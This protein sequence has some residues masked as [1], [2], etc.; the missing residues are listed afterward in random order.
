MKEKLRV[1]AAVLLILCFVSFL[2]YGVHFNC[3]GTSTET[4]M[5]FFRI[6]ESRQG[7]ILTVQS[8]GGI[9]MTVLLG[10]YGERINKIHGIALGLGVMGV[11]SVLIGTI[12]AYCRI[13]SGYGLMLAFSL[14][15]GLGSLTVDLLMNG[16]IT[17]V[18]PD[19]KNVFLPYVHAF[20]GV[21]AMLAPMYV[22]ALADPGAPE[23]FAVPYLILGI[24]AVVLCGVLFL[25]AVR[26]NPHTPY[27][28]MSVLRQR[29]CGNPAEVFRD[30]RA[31]LYLGACFLY[32]CFQ[33]GLSAWLPQYCMNELGYAYAS[34][35]KMA[36][37][38]FLGALLMRLV[39]PAIYKRISVRNFYVLT[40]SASAAV[41]ALFLFLPWSPVMTRVLI[42]VLGLLQGAS[43]PSMVILCSD[44]F[45]G[46]SASA[47]SVI[48]LSVSL[49]ALIAPGVMGAVIKNG[50]YLWAMLLIW[51]CLPLSILPLLLATREK[52]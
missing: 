35:A 4:M 7:M 5:G 29:A 9:V 17:D 20:Y 2:A 32:L 21:G 47:S 12:P 48:V 18:F 36:T 52:K 31:W 13:G 19:R 25:N 44:S 27:R 16:V 28:D 33:T 24:L 22:S 6:D 10:L 45:P 50:G 30:L 15:A 8:I 1:S 14:L 42:F 37:F 43:V 3:F 49:A 38:Y 51:V 26:V 23:T 40:I 34:S 11:A 46:R 39:S 41:F